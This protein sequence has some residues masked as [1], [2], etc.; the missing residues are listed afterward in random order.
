MSCLLRALT[1][2]SRSI[3]DIRV[4]IIVFMAYL[5]AFSV[6]AQSMDLIIHARGFKNDTGIAIAK[7]FMPGDNVRK[8]GHLEVTSTIHDG[9]A[10]M[11]FP[12][13][14]A[15][16]YAVVVFHDDNNNHEIDHNWIGLP[17]EGLG[18]SNGFKLG[19]TSGLPTFE[20]LRFSH[21]NQPQIL[22]IDVKE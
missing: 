22:V 7:L 9:N 21:S 14:P 1:P 8:H 10:E 16:D 15:G 12:A 11:I 13:M 17:S 2:T 6:N 18:F 4:A 3:S 19:L 20:K 5:V